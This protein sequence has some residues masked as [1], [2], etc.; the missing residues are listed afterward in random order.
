VLGLRDKPVGQHEHDTNTARHDIIVPGLARGPSWAVLG[1][2]DKPVGQ[3]EHDTISD[4]PFSPLVGP[5][6]PKSPARPGPVHL[7]PDYH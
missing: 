2:R 1:L 6:G 3:H 4:D 5:F 7:W